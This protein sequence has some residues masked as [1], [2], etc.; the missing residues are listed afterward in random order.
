MNRATLVFHDG[1]YRE[2][3]R[4]EFEVSLYGDVGYS[5][6]FDSVPT[7]LR[8][9]DDNQ[10]ILFPAENLVRLNLWN[11]EDEEVER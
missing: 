11:E 4:V 3:E 2:P 6:M 1:Q 9:W 5:L 7:M 8:V 10:T